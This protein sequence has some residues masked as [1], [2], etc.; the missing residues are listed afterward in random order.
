MTYQEQITKERIDE[1]EFRLNALE[2]KFNLKGDNSTTPL[3]LT[4]EDIDRLIELL[5]P[6]TQVPVEFRVC[7]I[8]RGLPHVEQEDSDHFTEYKLIHKCWQNCN[9]EMKNFRSRQSAI[10]YWNSI[11]K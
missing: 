7:P 2:S 1:L 11:V 4:L 3:G 5:P 8:C 6:E 10:K 9:I